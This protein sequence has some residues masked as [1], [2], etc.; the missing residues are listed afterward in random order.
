MKHRCH[1]GEPWRHYVVTRYAG[2]Y[3]HGVAMEIIGS[4]VAAKRIATTL[5]L[6]MSQNVVVMVLRCDQFSSAQKSGF[7]TYV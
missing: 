2:D 5:R 7:V 6:S 1:P 4:R 3:A